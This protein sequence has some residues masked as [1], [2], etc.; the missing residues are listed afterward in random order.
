MWSIAPWAPS[1]AGSPDVEDLLA[2]PFKR[3]L[4]AGATLVGLWSVLANS[5]TAEICAGA[6]FDWILLDAEHGPNDLQLIL[7]QLQAMAGSGCHPVVRP[8]SDDPAL[9]KQLL[10][11]GVQTLLVPMIDTAEQARRLVQSVRYPPRGVRGV[12]AGMARASQWGRHR[13]Y[14]RRA[15][16][17]TCLLV[18]VESRRGLENLDAIAE[19]DGV[20]GVFIGA[21]DLAADLGH[22]GQPGHPEVIAA[23]SGAIGRLREL[24]RP[25]GM[26]LV[27]E[28]HPLGPVAADCA[29]LAVGVDALLLAAG[30]DQ[31]ARTFHRPRP[32]A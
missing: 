3:G 1:P 10:D 11:I 32:G 25:S 21:A 9:I 6:G 20:D 22:L 12:G 29:F 30:A 23:V 14:L 8:R 13:Q 16:E 5:T 15:D 27:G 19:T 17:E 7:G 24:G 18:Q 26:L 28:G 4:S 31:L 2:N